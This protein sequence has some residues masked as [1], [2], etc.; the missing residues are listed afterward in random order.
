M[1]TNTCKKSLIP[2]FHTFIYLTHKFHYLKM[3]LAIGQNSPALMDTTATT[4]T[5][6]TTTNTQ[7]I[8]STVELLELALPQAL[9]ILT[10]STPEKLLLLFPNFVSKS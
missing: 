10:N 8:H 1:N 4:T 9:D 7:A 3:E 5:S 6:T 2:Y